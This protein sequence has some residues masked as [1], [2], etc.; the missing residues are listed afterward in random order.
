M[1]IDPSQPSVLPASPGR[2]AALSDRNERFCRG[3]SDQSLSGSKRRITPVT[4]RCST[5]RSTASSAGATRSLQGGVVL[6]EDRQASGSAT[7]AGPYEDAWH[8][9]RSRSR[10]RGCL[11]TL[12]G[13]RPVAPRPFADCWR[14]S[15]HRKEKNWVRQMSAARPWVRDQHWLRGCVV[16]NH[17]L[18]TPPVQ[19]FFRIPCRKDFS[20]NSVLLFR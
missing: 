15:I 20:R 9:A 16:I 17:F 5:W 14:T 12:R 1:S 8:G 10:I 2:R 19:T 11:G 18:L 7:V 4:S 6:Q 3:M 13:D